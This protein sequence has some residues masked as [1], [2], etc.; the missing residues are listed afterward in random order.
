MSRGNSNNKISF[1]DKLNRVLSRMMGKKD[2]SLNLHN[3]KL[4]KPSD[5]KFTI[6]VIAMLLFLWG[7]SGIYYVP[8][9]SYGLIMMNGKI[10]KQVSGLSVGVT[11]P[12]PFINVIIL[13]SSVNNSSIGTS[14][15][16]PLILSSKDH[17]N[18]NVSANFSY[19]I[20]NP[21]IYYRNYY[22]D[23]TDLDAKIKLEVISQFA[24]YIQAY[25][26]ADLFM[27]NRVVISDTVTDKLNSILSN[28]GIELDKITIKSLD[29]YRTTPSNF[30]ESNLQ[31]KS[32]TLISSSAQIL[33]EA[34]SY[35]LQ[36]LQQ[37]KQITNDFNRLL[38]DY[39]ISKS[40]VRELLYYKML[41]NISDSTVQIESFSL[42]NMSESQFE[43]ALAKP[44]NISSGQNAALLMPRELDRSVNRQRIL[45]R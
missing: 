11:M 3:N 18:I 38:P 41:N 12:Y 35:Q 37:V 23:D 26:V 7:C 9:K 4:Q 10:I 2:S 8:N 27:Q 28:N 45:G 31:N 42:L 5:G 33:I 22:Q 32:Q 19:A 20:K 24:N 15:D 40:M 43:Q 25:T 44:N 17:Q 36:K 21:I 16:D 13:D 1:V 39:Q 34:E 30:N 29:V 14:S 6:I